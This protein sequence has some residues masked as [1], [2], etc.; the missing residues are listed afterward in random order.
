[1]RLKLKFIGLSISE[2]VAH[3]VSVTTLLVMPNALGSLPVWFPWTCFISW[4]LKISSSTPRTWFPPPPLRNCSS[5][6][7]WTVI[8]TLLVETLTSLSRPLRGCVEGGCF[9]TPHGFCFLKKNRQQ[10]QNFP[11]C[12]SAP[13]EDSPARAIQLVLQKN[14][15]GQTITN[16]LY[17]KKNNQNTTIETNH[18]MPQAKNQIQLNMKSK[19]EC[20]VLVGLKITPCLC[21]L[22]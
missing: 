14:R 5:L 10:F 8:Y 16:V 7:V 20:N 17:L 21:C 2:L 11:N 1:M 6:N 18:K 4:K 15:C 13:R 9:H 12:C 3:G 22:T 19:G